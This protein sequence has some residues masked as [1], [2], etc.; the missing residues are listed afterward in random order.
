[1]HDA[2]TRRLMLS[3]N[4]IG[5]LIERLTDSVHE[6]VVEAL[7]ALR[8][9]TVVGGEEVISEM[10]NKNVL[11]PVTAL[12][13]PLGVMIDSML[14]APAANA[15][16]QEKRKTVWDWAENII[17]VVWAMCENSEKSLKVV[18]KLNMIPF[19]MSFMSNV[20]KL[21]PKVIVA[22]GTTPFIFKCI[23][24]S[25]LLF[26]A[27]LTHYIVFSSAMFVHPDRR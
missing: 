26:Y 16:E 7:G 5:A 9:L 11:T 13:P 8:N 15:Q 24:Q 21:P 19:L 1:M 22:A 23:S 12:I 14:T 6:V 4:L 25:T 3:K 17:S 27:F 20:D 18:N 2:A 10:Y